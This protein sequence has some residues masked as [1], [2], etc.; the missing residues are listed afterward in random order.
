M[1]KLN[2]IIQINIIQQIRELRFEIN[3]KKKDF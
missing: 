2:T 3:F 1:K